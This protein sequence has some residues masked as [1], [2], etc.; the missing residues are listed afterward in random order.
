[1][2]S[3]RITL[4]GLAKSESSFHTRVVGDDLAPLTADQARAQLARTG[5]PPKITA[6]DRTMIAVDIAGNG[7]TLAIYLVWLLPLQMTGGRWSVYASLFFFV[8]LVLFNFVRT[9]VR[10]T[11][12]DTQRLA[13]TA[14]VLGVPA[15]VVGLV[16]ANLPVGLS[17]LR[18]V[19]GAAIIA[20][21]YLVI[22]RRVR[23]GSQ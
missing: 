17:L 10:T 15:A 23:R 19:V 5:Q 6:R 12:L 14:V 7:V 4:E 11:P 18:E 22:A 20:L 16:V 1:M 13:L 2:R 21:P 8:F 9:R 3:A